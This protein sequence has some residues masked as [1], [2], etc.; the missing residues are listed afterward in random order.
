MY[1]KYRCVLNIQQYHR[2][3]AQFLLFKSLC[4]FNFSVHVLRSKQKLVKKCLHNG[5]KNL[6]LCASVSAAGSDFPLLVARR[7]FDPV[8]LEI[9]EM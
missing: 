4:L 7:H 5:V 6:T 3:M 9:T 8:K 2:I 1:T